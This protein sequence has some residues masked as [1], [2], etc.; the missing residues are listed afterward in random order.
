MNAKEPISIQ[1]K[2]DYDIPIPP[3]MLDS[4]QYES[5]CMAMEAEDITPD[6]FKCQTSLRGYSNYVLCNSVLLQLIQHVEVCVN[7]FLGDETRPVLLELCLLCNSSKFIETANELIANFINV[8]PITN[9]YLKEAE[10]AV[11]KMFDMAFT[12]RKTYSPD[13]ADIFDYK[14]DVDE[15]M[16]LVI[17][18]P[19]NCA[20]ILDNGVSHSYWLQLATKSY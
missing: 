5:P 17:S 11:A 9:P 4:A 18:L 12:V 3:F 15:P 14:T 20:G 1:I 16:L 7:K 6:Y 8:K 19:I 2:T 13:S 10:G